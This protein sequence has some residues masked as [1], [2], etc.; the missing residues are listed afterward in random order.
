M[1]RAALKEKSNGIS[2]STNVHSLCVL[3]VYGSV[4]PASEE[5]MFGLFDYFLQQALTVLQ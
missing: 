4:L 3:V 2:A 5:N 1:V